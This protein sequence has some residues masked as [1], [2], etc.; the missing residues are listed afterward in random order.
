MPKL[1]NV[2]ADELHAADELA[3]EAS[4]TAAYLYQRIE[5]GYCDEIE[6][7]IQKASAFLAASAALADLGRAIILKA[8]LQEPKRELEATLRR[9]AAKT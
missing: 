5:Q 4:Q 2:T 6:S 1:K 8:S 7:P 9:Q 3:V